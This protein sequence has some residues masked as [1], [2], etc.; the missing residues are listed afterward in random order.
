M[1]RDLF[2]KLTPETQGM[3]AFILGLILIL[4]T[5]GKL[6]ILQGMLNTIMIITGILL[7]LW[8]LH[9]TQGINKIY[10]YLQEKK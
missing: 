3:L 9:T 1:L 10:K 2:K 5:L 6:Q 4:G 8:G 7:V